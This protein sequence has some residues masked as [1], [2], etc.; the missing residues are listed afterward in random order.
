MA[1][2]FVTVVVPFDHKNAGAVDEHLD[3]LGNL[4]RPPI[5]ERLDA[6]GF[7]HFM[8]LTVVRDSAGG[9][10]H[11]VLEVSADGYPDG[12]LH[13]LA[14]E[15][16]PALRGILAVAGLPVPASQ[17][18]EFLVEHDRQIGQ[19][20]FAKAP[21]I[22]FTGTPGMT[23]GR[24][25]REELLASRIQNILDGLPAQRSAL[26]TLKDVRAQ[27]F[28]ESVYKWAFVAESVP[29]LADAPKGFLG[30]LA[31]SALRTLL[32]PLFVLPALVL[33]W[34]GLVW[35]GLVL[36]WHGL[37]WQG[38]GLMWQGIWRTL[39]VLGAELVLAL[40]ASR[41]AYVRLRHKEDRDVPDDRDPSARSVGE[42]MARENQCMQNHLAGVSTLKPGWL[43]RLTL[44]LALWVVG[45]LAA[46][47]SRP[48]FLSNIGTIHFARWI[49]LPGTDKL[50]FFSN[51]TGSWESYLEDFILRLHYG[52][53]GVWSNTEGFPRTR[54][55]VQDGAKDG[56]RFKRWG[57]RQQHPTR[58]WY[59]A[60]PELTTARVRINAAIRYGFATASTEDAA[61]RW[62]VDFRFAPPKIDTVESESI[63]TLV[64]GGL[65][66][67]HCARSL[68]LRFS[69]VPDDARA[70]LKEIESDIGYGERK[71]DGSTLVLGLSV[72]G[73][74]KLGLGEQA[75]STFP[76]AFQDGMAA[77]W[78]ARAL[79]DVGDN[80]PDSWCWGGPGNEADAVLN[81]YALSE[82]ILQQQS[83]LRKARLLRFG[84][85]VIYEILL[86]KTPP[87]NT[88][89]RE[90][91]GFTDGISQ[92]IVR[93]A[94][95]WVIA[96]NRI[97]VVE[98][99]EIILGYPDNFGYFPPSPSGADG[100]D[101]GRNGTYL[102]VRQLEQKKIDFDNFRESEAARLLG[103]PRVPAGDAQWL[104]DW[105]GAKI[106]GRWPDGTSLVRH[107][108][109]PGSASR[110]GTLPDNDFLFGTEDPDGLRCP[111]GAHIRR[112]NPRE[113]FDPGSEGQLA[114]SNRHRIF[115][116]GR[117]YAPQNGSTN[118]GLLFMCVN[119]NIERQFE[120]VQ[121]T[122][123]L[124]SGF[125]GLENEVD[126]LAR[127][128]GLSDVLTI[129]TEKGPLRLKGMGNFVRVRA[130]GYFFM[131][132]K[133]AVR[134]LI[135]GGP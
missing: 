69:S 5:S 80:A 73:L 46:Y 108:N 100:R 43:R 39:L 53:T 92:P 110:P 125:H 24:I 51:Y 7:V 12:V 19:G 44:R 56:D 8:S 107:P 57:R 67:L 47:R 45:A 91:F 93:G 15:I 116:V 21:G 30:P 18:G 85:Q 41:I 89:S 14:R 130:G 106:L 65:P 114:I 63:P 61:A 50:L 62:L 97:H 71:P 79:G 120:F 37:V 82:D 38:L 49:L 68:V 6:S 131:P 9:P 123:M 59:S 94:R 133:D 119:A 76:T 23:V 17:L 32:W 29:L 27:L 132:G 11:L 13:R 48:G 66:G 98:P 128:G 121:Q 81:L 115:R 70:W 31:R 3:A 54:Q 127:R 102:V 84:I 101:M 10:A 104:A 34:Q 129:P 99:G 86:D 52:L 88:P 118:P 55:L 103:D 90:S 75:L 2:A 42:I 35:H 28:R 87:K 117:S 58:F 134:F 124:G 40:I 74:R 126:S 33:V 26:A 4:A 135:G 1:H 22:V 109:Q 60:Y 77:P 111:F 25:R 83:D 112:V 105:I 78:R 113:S 72:S 64:F 122:W 36:V 96:R 95:K 16:G 20:W